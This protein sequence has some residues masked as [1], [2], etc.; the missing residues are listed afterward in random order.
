MQSA[1]NKANSG[2]H[3][4]SPPRANIP[5]KIAKAPKAE[6]FSGKGAKRRANVSPSKRTIS[7]KRRP[8]VRIAVGLA[9]GLAARL[10]EVG[11]D[12]RESARKGVGMTSNLRN[13]SGWMI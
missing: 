1:A 11:L 13:V 12:K 6:K 5:Q 3:Q 9:V 2:N 4:R 7:I 8:G 10:D